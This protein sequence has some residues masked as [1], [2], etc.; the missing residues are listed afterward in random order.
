MKEFLNQNKIDYVLFH[1]ELL[2]QLPKALKDRFRFVEYGSNLDEDNCIYFLLSNKDIHEEPFVFEDGIPIIF[3]CSQETTLYTKQG[4][5]LIINQDL[6]K[7]SFYF[8]SGYQEHNSS[9][10]DH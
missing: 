8:L 1:F 2:Y 7:S 3:P 6:F 4:N 9:K 5:N 10:K